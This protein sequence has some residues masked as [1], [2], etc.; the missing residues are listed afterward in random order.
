MRNPHVLFISDDDVVCRLLS[1]LLQEQ[2]IDATLVT[3]PE[4]ALRHWHGGRYD[5]LVIDVESASLDGAAI[6]YRLRAEVVNPIILAAYERDERA[7]I[8]AYEA[9]AD[10]YIVKPIGLRLYCCKVIAWLRHAWT[11]PVHLLQPL[12]RGPFSLHAQT[13]QLQLSHGGDAAVRLT[14]LEFRLLHLLMSHE[15]QVLESAFIADRLWGNLN[16]DSTAALKSLVYR[17]RQKIEPVPGRPRYLQAA[18][19]KGYSFHSR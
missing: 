1:I 14:N 17:V 12:E 10:D 8:A 3:A 2:G 5:L 15:G 16:V 9:G 18:A 6:C 11:V 19:G 13:R 7:I 4:A